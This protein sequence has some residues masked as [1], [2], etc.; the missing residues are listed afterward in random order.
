MCLVALAV[1]LLPAAAP[2]SGEVAMAVIVH[3]ENPLRDVKSSDLK[4]YL[5][6]DRQFWPNGKRVVLFLPPS[7]SAAKR[8]LNEKVYGMDE[9]QLRKYWVRKVY[10]GEI[11]KPPQVAKGAAAAGK[12]VAATE[13]AV[14][15]VRVDELPEGVRVLTIDGKQPG[16][17]GYPLTGTPESA[18]APRP[19][20]LTAPRR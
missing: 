10:A 5:R 1:L 9:D 8:A 17:E 13:G 3:G 14:S 20:A 6:L 2:R 11:P 15:V 4:G 12:L 19:E 7:D 16:E 18:P